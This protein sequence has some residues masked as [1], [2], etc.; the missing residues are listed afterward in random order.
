[1]ITQLKLY[2]NALMEIGERAL[3]ALT[4]ENESRRALDQVWD[5]GEL[6]DYLLQQG[7]W[8]FASRTSELTYAPSIEPSFGYQYAISKP[9]DWVK[10]TMLS[11]DEYFSIPLTEYEDEREYWFCEHQTIY[12]KY[13]SNDAAY[14]DDLSLWPPAFSRWVAVYLASRVCERLT[15]NATKAA[16]LKAAADPEAKRPALL[17]AARSSDAMDEPSRAAAPGSWSLSRRRHRYDKMRGSLI[18]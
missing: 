9:S 15:Q 3:P 12:V 8:N 6:I 13:V 7:H 17:I 14:G 1:M 11:A 4:D 18:G 10:T 5:S 2:N 16:E